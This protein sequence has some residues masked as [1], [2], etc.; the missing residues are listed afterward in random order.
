VLEITE[1]SLLDHTVALRKLRALKDL[2][3]RLAV[4]DFGTGYSSLHY[5]ERFP[6]DMLKI[7]KPFIDELAD[8]TRGTLAQAIVELGRTFELE[9]IAEGIDRSE[10]IARLRELGCCVG[11]G[12]LLSH[13]LDREATE[14]LLHKPE[15]GSLLEV[16]AA[17]GELE[18]GHRAERARFRSRR[19]VA[20]P[21]R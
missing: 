5:L 12:F 9:V 16:L 3:V 17:Q 10:H 2:G 20:S 13:P 4:D 18:L 6:V 8:S 1:T 7:A 15:P 11:Q 14:Q 19:A 21:F